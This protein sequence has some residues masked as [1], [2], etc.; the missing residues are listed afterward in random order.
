MKRTLYG[1]T[2]ALLLPGLVQA[3]GFDRLACLAGQ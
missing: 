2:T 1:L 3:T